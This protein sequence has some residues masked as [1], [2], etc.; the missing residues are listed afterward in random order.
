V[1]DRDALLHAIL[2]EPAENTPRLV[3]ADWLDENGDPE[4]AA[5]LRT[6]YPFPADPR[7]RGEAYRRPRRVL[8]ARCF[9]DRGSGLH[10]FNE[11]SEYALSFPWRPGQIAVGVRHGFVASLSCCWRHFDGHARYWFERNPIQQVLLHESRDPHD[12]IPRSGDV[13][14]THSRI[15]DPFRSSQPSWGD[16]PCGSTSPGVPKP[17]W[18]LLDGHIQLLDVL[19]GSHKLYRTAAEARAA[20]SRALVTHGRSLCGLPPLPPA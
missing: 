2:L 18:R 13:P 9:P 10:C 8:H 16:V 1:T 17:I 4:W 7:V 3:L 15:G 12:V 20:M 14:L 6:R 19:Y 11:H 5:L